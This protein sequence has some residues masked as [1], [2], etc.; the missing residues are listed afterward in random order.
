MHDFFRPGRAPL[1]AGNAAIATS[2]PLATAA[3]LDILG[4]GGNAV[5]A[6][7]AAVAVQCVADPL[8]TGIGGDC[9]VLYQPAGGEVVGLNGSGRAPAAATVERLL[10]LGVNEIGQTSPHSVTVPGAIAAWSKLHRDYGRLPLSRLFERAIDYSETGYPVAARV[11]CDW[12]GEVDLLARTAGATATFLPGGRAP[13]QGERHHQ[14]LLGQRLREIGRDGAAAFYTG[15]TAQSLVA[16]L[17]GLGGLHTLE[18]FAEAQDGADYATPV[19]ASYR[20]YEVVE[21]APNGQGIIALMILKILEGFDIAALSPVDRIH[22]HA[23]ATKLAYHHRDAYLADPA[24]C[25]EPMSMLSDEI[26]DILRARI[27]LDR[28]S[29]PV[30]WSEP[31]HKDTIYLCVVDRDG[32]AI[33]FINSIFDGFGSGH[34]DP[35]TGVLLHSRGSSFRIIKGHPNAIAPRKRPLHTIIPGLLR[36]DGQVAMP[37]GV[38]GGHYQAAGH[39]QFLSNMLDLGLDIQQ[40][41]DAPRSFA[42][43]GVLEVEPT[44]PEADLAELVRRGHVLKPRQLPLGGSQAIWIDR[45][46]RTLIAGSDQRKDGCALGM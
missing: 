20:G 37:F 13:K 40:A 8:M 28:A 24:F 41:M 3:G 32:N 11:A 26:I 21:C 46:N 31:E 42:H 18:D 27:R 30:L 22:L 16:Y 44:I 38:M 17:N 39:A 15:K 29:T 2:H 12:A 33:S 19:S 4:A 5:D 7:I 9:F 10:S 6:A 1:I 35:T 45:A 34:V 25:P 23:E 36:K 14:P 43:G